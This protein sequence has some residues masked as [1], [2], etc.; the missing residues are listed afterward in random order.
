LATAGY[1]KGIYLEVL[2]ENIVTY[3]VVILLIF[4]LVYFQMKKGKKQSKKVKE[5]IER[6]KELGLNNS[7]T[8]KVKLF[9]IP[10]YLDGNDGIINKTYYQMLI[11]LDLTVF[12][13]YY[14]PWGYTPLESLAFEVPT[15]TTSL[16]GFGLWVNDYYKN[17]HPGIEVIKRTDSNDDYVTDTLSIL[18]KSF[19]ENDNDKRDSIKKNALDVSKIAL[20]ENLIEHYYKAYHIALSKVD[21]RIDKLLVQDRQEQ[22]PYIE[23]IV[24]VNKPNWIRLMIFS[25]I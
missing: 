1:S 5:K 10:C 25:D 7:E 20:W 23:Q 12:P 15:I 2:I 13:S 3:S 16:A 11:G 18:I 6:A 9:F 21:E 19:T 14:E 24:A 8:D 4:L 22:L 17:E